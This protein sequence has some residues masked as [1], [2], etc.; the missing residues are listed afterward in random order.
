MPAERACKN[1]AAR[2]PLTHPV[3]DRWA[4]TKP[5]GGAGREGRGGRNAREPRTSERARAMA[6]ARGV[7]L[8]SAGLRVDRLVGR[9]AD[10]RAPR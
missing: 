3:K 2:N 8:N 6:M 4:L 7:S 5:A 10:G 9:R 1:V